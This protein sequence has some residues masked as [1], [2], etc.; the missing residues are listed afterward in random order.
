MK[1]RGDSSRDKTRLCISRRN[2]KHNEKWDLESPN[3]PV[4]KKTARWIEEQNEFL[5]KQKEKGLMR[6]K[7]KVVFQALNQMA[8]LRFCRGKELPVILV[9]SDNPSI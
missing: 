3:N 9:M 7:K 4:D 6:I 8:L 1:V 2:D 5:G